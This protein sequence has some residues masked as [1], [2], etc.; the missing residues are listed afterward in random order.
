MSRRRRHRGSKTNTRSVQ[1]LS[2]EV[3]INTSP[4]GAGRSDA[5]EDEEPS[6]NFKT[7]EDGG[8]DQL[9]AHLTHFTSLFS[10]PLDLSKRQ[11][12]IEDRERKKAFFTH[13]N[14]Q[15]LKEGR[16]KKEDFFQE[17]SKIP[18]NPVAARPYPGDREKSWF[19]AVNQSPH[20]AGEELENLSLLFDPT[21][22]GQTT[23]T[24]TDH[25]DASRLVRHELRSEGNPNLL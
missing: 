12:T 6:Y 14:C 1:S 19:I 7:S 5:A 11:S 3:S 17:A 9:R 8:K 16:K 13:L 24:T 15:P 22:P 10:P 21:D 2:P 4:I 18:K 23:T 20:L 25:C